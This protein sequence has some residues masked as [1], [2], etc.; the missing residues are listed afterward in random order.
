MRLLVLSIL[1]ASAVVLTIVGITH[2][3]TDL[4][5][6]MAIIGVMTFGGCT[7]A[8]LLEDMRTPDWASSQLTELHARYLILKDKVRDP[9]SSFRLSMLFGITV[10]MGCAFVAM[11]RGCTPELFFEILFGAS[12]AG[13]I[14][15][16][17]VLGFLNRKTTPAG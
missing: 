7:A 6:I 11:F 17:L 4:P 5:R 9:L 12:T 13:L 10:G 8:V 15:S 2:N 14:A 3:P 1:L 16:T